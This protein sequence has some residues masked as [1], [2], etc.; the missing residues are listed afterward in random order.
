MY[1]R[2][3]RSPPALDPAELRKGLTPAQLKAL[4]TLEHFQWT[5]RFVR[6]PLFRDPIPVVF[7]RDGQRWA[8]L[9]ADGGI[10][11]SPG[12]QLRD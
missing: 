6:R 4:E 12:F 5:L 3:R 1:G 9:E 8:V 7:N 10:N 2:E 11:E